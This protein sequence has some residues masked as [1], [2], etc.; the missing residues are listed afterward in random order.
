MMSK[1]QI[2]DQIKLDE[3]RE[4][5]DSLKRIERDEEHDRRVHCIDDFFLE[6][7]HS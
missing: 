1:F 4:T 6:L 5:R 3:A 2:H 7:V